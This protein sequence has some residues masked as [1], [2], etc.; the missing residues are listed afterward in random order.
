MTQW[1]KY[2]T[3]RLAVQLAQAWNYGGGEV[4]Q[5][6]YGVSVGYML[7]FRDAQKTEYYVDRRRYETYIAGLHRL[8]RDEVFLDTF[9]PEAQAQLES[10]WEQT[11]AEFARGLS[12]RSNHEFAVLHQRFVVP[13]GAEFYARMWT[14]FNIAKP[15]EEVVVHFLQQRIGG[16]PDRV[17]KVLLALSTPLQPNDVLQE[18]INLLRL[19]SRRTMMGRL[20]FNQQLLRHAAAYRHIPM[21]DI[22]HRPYSVDHFRR[23]LRRVRDPRRELRQIEGL[24]TQHQKEFARQLTRLHPNRRMRK[25]LLFLKRNVFLRDHR[26]M[27][28]QKLN[29]ELRKYYREVGRRLDLTTTQVAAMTNSEIQHFL[30][31]GQRFPKRVARQRER[32][33]LLIQRGDQLQI[34][35]GAEA[36]SRAKQE[37]GDRLV[38]DQQTVSGQIASLGRARGVV[39]IVYTNRDLPKVKK[40][41]ILVTTMTR[42]DFVPAMRRA[43]AIVTDEGG[44]TS[45]AAIIS[46]ELKIPCVVGTKVATQVFKDG[47]RVEVDATRGI[48]RKI[49]R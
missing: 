37:L 45:H 11:R 42:Q 1:Q 5:R 29:L 48:V 21:F 35:S 46:R 34:F 22:D 14:V 49:E 47:D 16:S 39:R 20:D 10:I 13:L 27:I 38:S 44:V 23:E 8:L 24:F 4:M 40:G 12:W 2:V 41:D 19:A 30:R 32:A 43:A 36:I 3:L 31:S 6:A 9:H 28:R 33:F 17:V 7:V 18:R 26:D 15:L 25:V